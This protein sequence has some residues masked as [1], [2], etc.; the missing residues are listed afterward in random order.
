[1]LTTL[2]D[3]I[4]V[5]AQSWTSAQNRNQN[6]LL[7]NKHLRN[8]MVTL[9]HVDWSRRPDGRPIELEDL[10]GR[11]Y[12]PTTE[13]WIPP[14]NAVYV[15]LDY[16]AID[17]SVTYKWFLKLS[18]QDIIDQQSKFLWAGLSQNIRN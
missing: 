17:K 11:S 12:S 7:Y 3:T 5:G 18:A 8:S 9:R 15:P 13:Q 2:V 14:Y 6:A 4:N 16:D 1:M 10:F